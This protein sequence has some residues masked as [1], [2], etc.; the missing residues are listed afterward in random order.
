VSS[1]LPNREQ[2]LELLHK[3]KVPPQVIEHC[4]AVADFAMETAEKLKGREV[5]VN[6]ELVEAGALLHD[7]GRSKCHSVDHAVVGAQ[8]AQSIGLPE[9]VIRIIKRHVGAGIT[10]KEAKAL[11]WP[12]DTYTPQTIEEK[13]VCYADKR[14][15]K[16]KVIPVEV[17]I[18]KLKK[19]NKV[20][21]AERVR[22]LSDEIT[23][24]LGKKP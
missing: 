17:E 23:S 8:I 5:K 24:L 11:G 14:I 7:L 15:D 13:V 12:K 18:E 1:G 20:E 16:S 2:A 21:A 6:V 22:K 19:D 10:A 4:I 9:P 3:N